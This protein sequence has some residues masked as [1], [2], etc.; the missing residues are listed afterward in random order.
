MVEVDLTRLD[1]VSFANGVG[2]TF[3]ANPAM[4]LLLGGPE[5]KGSCTFVQL[6][7]ISQVLH[8]WIAFHPPL[9]Q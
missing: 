6:P 1:A 8:H 5:K 2:Q 9:Q 3:G 4:C 7:L